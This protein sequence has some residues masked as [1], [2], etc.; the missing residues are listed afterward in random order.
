MVDIF[1]RLSIYIYHYIIIFIPES[2]ALL[3]LIILLKNGDKK[4]F[5]FFLKRQMQ[6][7]LQSHMFILLKSI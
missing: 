6:F 2:E 3:K 4:N 7:Q 1:E 5:D